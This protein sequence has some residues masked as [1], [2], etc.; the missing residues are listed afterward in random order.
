[1]TTL[2]EFGKKIIKFS[3]AWKKRK[4]GP[5]MI[6]LEHGSQQSPNITMIK[7]KRCTKCKKEKVRSEKYFYKCPKTKLGL[8]AKCKQCRDEESKIWMRKTR[9]YRRLKKL[10]LY[11]G[12]LSMTDIRLRNKEVLVGLVWELSR[13]LLYSGQRSRFCIQCE[14]YHQNKHKKK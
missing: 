2:K 14:Q 6:N 9:F 5:A 13:E 10:G 3:L 1:M 4:N 8:T 11:N 12:T 7:L